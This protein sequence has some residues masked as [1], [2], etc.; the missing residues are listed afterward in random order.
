MW[1]AQVAPPNLPISCPQVVGRRFAP[2]SESLAA[3]QKGQRA[4]AQHLHVFC[5]VCSTCIVSLHHTDLTQHGWV[6][7]INAKA[8]N[9]NHKK[10]LANQKGGNSALECAHVF[11][12]TLCF[13]V[14]FL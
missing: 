11:L 7:V 6:L 4:S 8:D 3:Q 12:A 2:A 13:S 9:P 1:I 10:G 14:V 5:P